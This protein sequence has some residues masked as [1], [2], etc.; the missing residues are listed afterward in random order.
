MVVVAVFAVVV[1]VEIVKLHLVVEVVG[2]EVVLVPA[3]GSNPV[4]AVAGAVAALMK[5]VGLVVMVFV[6]AETLVT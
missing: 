2:V 3:S 1:R 5:V 4:V 6:A